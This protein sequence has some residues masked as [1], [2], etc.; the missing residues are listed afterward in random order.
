MLDPERVNTLEKER[1]RIREA[2]QKK[3]DEEAEKMR[4]Q[5]KKEKRHK[6]L[7]QTKKFDVNDHDHFNSGYNPLMGGS[8]GQYVSSTVPLTCDPL[9][10]TR[11]CKLGCEYHWLQ[12]NCF[13]ISP[14]L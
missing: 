3:Y 7:K 5:K 9:L 8:S 11:A 2:Q 10:T 4:A 12:T 14:T 6:V 1:R 13:V